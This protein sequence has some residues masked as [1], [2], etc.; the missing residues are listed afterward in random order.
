MIDLTKSGTVSPGEAQRVNASVTQG[1][2]NLEEHNKRNIEAEDRERAWTQE[3]RDWVQASSGN[4][5]TA[6]LDREL[7][8][9]TK[10]NKAKRRTILARLVEEGLVSRHPTRNGIFRKLDKELVEMDITQDVGP[11]EDITLPFD[12]NKMVKLYAGNIVVVA[13]EKSAG[14][15]ALLLNVMADNL[16]KRKIYYFNSEMG[17]EE[18]S[19][20]IRAFPDMDYKDFAK[21]VKM[22]ERSHDFAEVIRPGKGNINII[23]YMAIYENHYLIG[24]WIKDVHDV[25]DGAIAFIALQKNPGRDMGTGGYVTQ[26]IARLYLAM[27]SGQ[28]KIVNA[29]NRMNPAVNPDGMVVNFKL[30][31]GC[32][33]IQ[34]D[35]WSLPEEE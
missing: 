22:Y 31:G 30:V 16:H 27:Q 24:Q 32:Q 13:G 34:T 1:V 18:L 20:R 15:T 8:I 33:F 25:L 6:Q 21:Y 9:V 19:L 2:T 17:S 26:E 7:E 11:G 4:F 23:D 29:K 12:L 5:S 35:R 3:I 10:R 14:K 28:L